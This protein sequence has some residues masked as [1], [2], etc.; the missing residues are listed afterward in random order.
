M[1][2]IKYNFNVDK[3]RLC[4]KQP[5]QLFDLLKGY[6]NGD[7]IN[8]DGFSLVITDCC[9]CVESN[10]EPTKIK[11]DVVI[12]D[13]TLL[14]EFVFNDS[15]KY[16]GKCF[17]S[18]DNHALYKLNGFDSQGNKHNYMAFVD[19]VEQKLHLDKNNLTEVEIALDVNFNPIPQ[20]QRL[21]RDTDS[22]DMIV[23]GKKVDDNERISG[24]GEYFERTRTKRKRYPTIYLSQRKADSPSLKV[25]D[26]LSEINEE[27]GK[28]YVIAWNEFNNSPIWRMEVTVKNVDFREFQE[29]I[30]KNIEEWGNIES[31]V[32]L[33]GLEQFKA[34]LW[35][36]ITERLMYFRNKHSN[37][38]VSLFD[39]A[40]K[41]I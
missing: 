35:V 11:A 12:D 16:E 18:V 37:E 10:K 27:S 14:G 9:R 6:N 23:N 8:F 17:F 28:D 22:Y 3:L 5:Q 30:S 21:I 34:L 26:K 7:Y 15:A 1:R 31:V 19:W 33:L 38:V 41:S 29:K 32:V 25:Y 39:I 36:Y 13:G 24:Y 4:Y 2:K 40:T 20:L